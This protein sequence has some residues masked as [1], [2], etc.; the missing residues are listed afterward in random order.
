[1]QASAAQTL[2][3]Q[4]EVARLLAWERHTP[5]PISGPLITP[6]EETARAY[7]DSQGRGRDPRGAML[8]V[9]A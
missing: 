4:G 3:Q 1:M 5:E 8:D 7:E 9:R 2:Y 6:V